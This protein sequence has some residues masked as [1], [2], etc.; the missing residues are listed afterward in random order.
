MEK[1]ND[2]LIVDNDIFIQ[3]DSVPV[4]RHIDGRAS[5][6]Q[7]ITHLIRESGL[8]VQIVAERNEDAIK[9]NLTR[10]EQ[11][12]EADIRIIPGTARAVRVEHGVIYI[13]AKTVEYNQ[14]EVYL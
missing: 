2:L 8:L 10:I 14:F 1:Y 3:S 6:A 7:D 5:I 11:K 13:T 4:E 9:L 12:I